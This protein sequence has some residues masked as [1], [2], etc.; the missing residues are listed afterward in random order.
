MQCKLSRAAAMAAQRSDF[1]IM[2]RPSSQPGAIASRKKKAL[3]QLFCPLAMLSVPF[4][5]CDVARVGLDAPL[6]ACFVAGSVTAKPTPHKHA[7][8]R[9]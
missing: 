2:A 3:G 8:R 1:V 7:A 9:K 5:A 6:S 4:P